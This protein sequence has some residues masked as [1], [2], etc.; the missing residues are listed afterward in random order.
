MKISVCGNEHV[1]IGRLEDGYQRVTVIRD[2]ESRLTVDTTD[3][4]IEIAAPLG[5]TVQCS[6]DLAR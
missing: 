3:P 5:E 2:G 6:W 4:N 1:H